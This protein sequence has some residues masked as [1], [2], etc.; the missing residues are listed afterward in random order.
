MSI[1]WLINNVW[2]AFNEEDFN[3]SEALSW[4]YGVS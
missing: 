2:K 1:R 3:I 4:F